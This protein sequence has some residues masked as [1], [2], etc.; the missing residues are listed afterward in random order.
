M[1][2]PQA[3]EEQGI[4]EELGIGG[5]VGRETPQ[6]FLGWRRNQN[7]PAL[8]FTFLNISKFLS[9]CLIVKT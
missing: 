8:D 3:E 4:K 5:L 9:Y 6:Q 1:E 7:Q 2:L